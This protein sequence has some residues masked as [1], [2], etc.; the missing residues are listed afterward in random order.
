MKRLLQIALGIIAAIGGFVDIGDLVFNAQAGAVFGYELLWV[1]PS[2]CSG[3]SS[4][5][6]CAAASPRSSR[7]PD[8][9]ARRASAR[10]TAGLVHAHRRRWSLTLLTLAAE[11][12]GIAIMLQLLFERRPYAAVVLVAVIA[13]RGVIWVLPFGGSSDLRLRRAGAARVPSPQRSSWTGLGRGRHG[14]VPE[15]PRARAL[16]WYFVVG[17]LARRDDAVRGLLLLVGRGRGGVDGEGPRRQPRQRDHRLRAR[18][19]LSVALMMPSAQLLQAAR[20]RLPSTSGR[21]RWGRRCPRRDG[22]IARARRD[23]VRGRRRGDRHRFSGAYNLAQFHGWEW[24][25]L[26]AERRVHAGAGSGPARRR[27]RSSMTGIDPIELTEY[28]VIFSVVGAAAHLP[29][30]AAR[31]ERQ[32]RTWGARQ[33]PLRAPRS[34]WELLRRDPRGRRHCDPAAARDERGPGMSPRRAR[35]RPRV[36]DHQLVDTRGAAAARWT[37]SSWRARPG[38]SCASPLCS[39]AR[40]PGGGGL[41]GPF[42]RLTGRLVCPRKLVR[43]P[44]DVVESAEA[45]VHL[46][47]SGL[48]R[49]RAGA[50][51]TTGGGSESRGSRGRGRVSP[52]SSTGRW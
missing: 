39:L 49:A 47:K 37:T 24:G 33:R 17:L 6:R 22:L 34:G 43:V 14:F 50:G 45:A 40:V 15:V 42:A 32:R 28:A 29:A 1:V 8:F 21:S 12:G 16:Y 19:V 51:A 11:I 30:D 7:K 10:A 20:D 27:S 36:L 3:S 48:R 44:W 18:R 2:A 13:A 46:G 9:D 52:S 35:P 31:R 4:S 41:P 26:G 23:A 38:R 25:K 5:P